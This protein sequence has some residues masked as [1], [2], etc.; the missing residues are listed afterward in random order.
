MLP[1]SASYEVDCESYNPVFDGARPKAI[2]YVAVSSDVSEMVAFARAHGLLLSVRSGG[3]SYGGWSTGPGLVVDVSLMNGVSVAAGAAPAASIGAGARLVDLYATCGAKGLSVPGGS[4]P[5]VGVAG[6]ALGGGLGVLDRRYGLTC[7]NLTSIDIVLASGEQVTCDARS[8]PDLF[9]ALRGAGGGSFGVVTGFRANAHPIGDLAIFTLVWDWSAAEEVVQAWQRWAPTAPDALWSN[10]LLLA[11]QTT[12]SGEGAVARVTGV[13]VGSESDLESEL[14][15]LLSEVPASPFDHFVGSAPYL[16]TMLIEAGCDGKSVA[17]CHLPTANQSGTLT[18]APF[19]AKSDIV[20]TL[21]PGAG[22]RAMLAA[23]Q[24]R[25]VSP[26]LSGGGIALDPAGGAINRVPADATAFVH[27]NALF[28][29][30][31]SANWP[32]GAAGALVAANRSWLQQAWS[33]MRAYVS[34]QA[35]QNYA[36]PALQGWARAYYGTNL[37]R[38]VEVKRNYDPKNVFRFAQSVPLQLA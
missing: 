33:S 34:G 37:S 36:D 19:A 12:P 23:V 14:S 7:D 26:T 15:G 18:R 16:D 3:H 27:R 17:E 1:S 9:W 35:Y 22:V 6:L 29:M 4:C 21:V 13:Y 2:A 28:T 32:T 8:H 20:T 25:Q 24:A 38:L 10:C 5:S 11:S 31:Y 30:Q